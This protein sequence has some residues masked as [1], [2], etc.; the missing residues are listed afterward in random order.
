MKLACRITTLCLLAILSYEVHAQYHYEKCMAGN[1][2]NGFGLKKI[3]GNKFRPF[4]FD[5]S[6]SGSYE[7]KYFYYVLGEFKGGKL[8]GNGYRFDYGLFGDAGTEAT[9][10]KWMKEKTPVIPDSKHFSW[11]ESGTY[12]NGVL[13]GKGFVIE[14]DTKLS[15]PQRIHM[16]QFKAGLLEGFGTKIIPDSNGYLFSSTDATTQK[17]EVTAG[18]IF[19]GTFKANVCTECTLTEKKDGSGEGHMTG[20]KIDE[21][22]LTGWVIRDFVEN[23]VTKKFT[24]MAP[25]RALYIGG[26][27]VG[28]LEGTSLSAQQKTID[29]GKEVTYTGETDEKGMPYGF[30]RIQYPGPR[31]EV[32]EGQ[33]DNGKPNGF[34]YYYSPGNAF[35]PVA[36]GFF[37]NDRLMYGGVKKQQADMEVILFGDPG[38][39]IDPQYNTEFHDVIWGTFKHYYYTYDRDKRTW[40]LTRQVSGTKENGYVKDLVAQKGLT[41]AEKRKQRAVTNGEISISDVVVG[42][43]IVVNGIASPVVSMMASVFTLKNGKSVSSLTVSGVRLS[44]YT[45]IDF[46]QA[47]PV[48]SGRGHEEYTYTRPPETVEEYY[49]VNETIVGDYTIL[50]HPI[51]QTRTVTK[52][53]R[54]EKRISTCA[55]CQG[56][57]AALDVKELAEP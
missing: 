8:N 15:R 35:Q 13:E 34:G 36:G 41:D 50:T 42:D 48:C 56:A 38:G 19:V 39:K 23:S 18:R 43:I 5:Q 52:T 3:E 45:E 54:P 55:A 27:Q 21:N 40:N 10:L 4:A 9:I 24:T 28:K 30:G 16:G 44:K 47:C 6:P 17:I 7:A 32:Y 31:N 33:F 22:F 20:S 37:R 11:F 2:K 46:H 14:Y 1:C 25:H 57:G 12:V 29:L 49:Y 51:L 53:Y 26:F